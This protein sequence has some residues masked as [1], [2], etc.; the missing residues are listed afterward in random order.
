[1]AIGA[2]KA[3][4]FA[5]GHKVPETLRTLGLT[6]KAR[7]LIATDERLQDLCVMEGH[8]MTRKRLY[9]PP[10]TR[11]RLDTPARSEAS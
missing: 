3:I 7:R 10:V 6:R 4:R 5:Y 9:A 1:M 8:F 2:T 11:N